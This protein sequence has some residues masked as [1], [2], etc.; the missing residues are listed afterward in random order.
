MFVEGTAVHSAAFLRQ[1]AEEFVRLHWS[2][3]AFNL[4]GSALIFTE[5]LKFYRHRIT[6]REA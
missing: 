1:T 4:A 5:F 2:R 3:L 6:S